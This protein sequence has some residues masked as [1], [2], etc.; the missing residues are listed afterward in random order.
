MS[1]PTPQP[2]TAPT[3]V[4]VQAL[5]DSGEV[6]RILDEAASQ[7]RVCFIMLARIPPES[8][9]AQNIIDAGY[10]EDFWISNVKIGVQGQD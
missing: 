3:V 9:V 2:D 8:S 4:R 10:P 1:T 6:K 5:Y 7:A